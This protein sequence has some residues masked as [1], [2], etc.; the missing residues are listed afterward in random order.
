MDV[1]KD[2]VLGW[3]TWD[4]P[5]ITEQRKMGQQTVAR[6]TGYFLCAIIGEDYN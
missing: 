4:Q 5:L 1:E 2:A 6:D 3:H